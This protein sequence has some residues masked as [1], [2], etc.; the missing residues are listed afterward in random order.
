MTKCKDCIYYGQ[1]KTLPNV[2]NNPK[3]IEYGFSMN[4]EYE[5]KSGISIKE[6]EKE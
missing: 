3:A 6:R 4:K 1:K 5:C 2:C